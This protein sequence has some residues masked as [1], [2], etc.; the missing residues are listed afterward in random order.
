MWRPG[1]AGRHTVYSY[2]QAANLASRLLAYPAILVA[3]L[4]H[5]YIVPIADKL[6]G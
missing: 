4:Q 5:L 6:H 1:W 2:P 3:L